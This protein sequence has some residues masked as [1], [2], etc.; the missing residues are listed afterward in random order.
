VCAR[1]PRPVHVRAEVA[2]CNQ[3]INRS[4]LSSRACALSNTA[5]CGWWPMLVENGRYYA[6][7]R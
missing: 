4:F 7:G 6:P 2:P 5:L 3:S 1:H